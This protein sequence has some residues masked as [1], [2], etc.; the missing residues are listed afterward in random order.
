MA[1]NRKKSGFYLHLAVVLFGLAGLLGKLITESPLTIVF[2]RT[3]IAAIIILGMM[4]YT[5]EEI[6]I[7]FRREWHLFLLMGILLALHWL[8]FFQAIKVSTMAIALLT[9]ASFPVFVTLIEPVVLKTRLKAKDILFALVVMTGLLIIVPE[10]DF[11]NQYTVGVFW[12][13]ISGFSFALLTVLNKLMTVA[14]SSRK[15]AF[16][17]NG[18]AALIVLPFFLITPKCLSL[19]DIGYLVILGVLCTAMAHTLF[20]ASMRYVRAFT[21]GIAATMEPVYGM[22]LALIILQEVPAL[23]TVVGGLIILGTIGIVTFRAD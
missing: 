17:Q 7:K 11:H 2:F 6:K 3:S 1:F 9:Y 19:A 15:I 20:I 22:I 12:G 21:A 14:H 16:Y 8:S 10:F 13:I 4:R 5:G 23:R 18:I